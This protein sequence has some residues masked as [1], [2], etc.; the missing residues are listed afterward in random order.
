MRGI[1]N[2][3]QDWLFVG[4]RVDI[5]ESDNLF[6]PVTLPH[7]NKT[8]PTRYVNNADY[9]FVSTYRKYFTLPN[10]LD[11][12]C[13][14]LKFDGAM[15]ETTVY[16][17]GCLLGNHQGGYTPFQFEITDYIRDDDNRLTVY[18]DATEHPHIP[19]YGNLV[20]FLTFGGIY[21]DVHLIVVDACHMRDVIT[22]P[23]D[24]LTHPKVE[25]SVELAHYQAGL[26]LEATL[27][28]STDTI[29]ASRTHRVESEANTFTIANLDNVDLWS[30]DSPTLYTLQ[31]QLTHH[32][33]V[34]DRLEQKIGFRDAKFCDDGHFYL[35]G[36]ALKLF[37]LNRHQTYP[38]IGAAAPK[39]LQE[40][41]ADILKYELGCNIVRTSHY[42]QSPHFLN[43]CD[44]IGLLVFEEV[45]GWQF[46]GDEQWQ[47]L[48]LDDLEAMIKRDRHHPAIVLWGVRV[49]ES[50]DHETFYQRTNA[51][52][53]KLDSS[54]QTGG[55][56]NF[57]ES[58]QLEDVFTLNDF[59]DIIQS[60]RPPHL[61]TEF[62][63]H[64]FPTKTSDHEARRV[65]HALK[66]ASKHNLQFGNDGVAGAIGWCA[67]DY[68]THKEFGS[69]DRICYHGVMD[70]FRLPKF[71][72]YFYRSQKSPDDEIVLFG[73]TN[74]TMG[75]R[76]GGGN[77]PLV[78]F[79]NCEQIELL[80]GDGSQGV[81][82]PNYD[83][84]PHLPYPP[85]VV[86]WAEPYNPWGTSFEDLTV[87]G[88]IDGQCVK[89][90]KIDASHIPHTLVVTADTTQL[91]ADGSD[92]TRVSVKIVDKHG[93]V[94]PYQ[95]SVLTWQIEGNAT[96]VGENPMAL[97]G[98]QG[99]CFV[100]SG[101]TCEKITVTASV[102]T[103]EPTTVSID[104]VDYNN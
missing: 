39:R 66:H 71:A 20:D 69:G 94:L 57:I 37:G 93:N 9:Q 95:S 54:R 26:E 48:V 81:F 38:F 50:P 78:V 15:L 60:P 12:K 58:Q 5:A 33:R 18:V 62:G 89:E 11:G 25:I 51:L 46:I 76:D 19:P 96:F 45:A 103:L 44:E 22:T 101:H 91:F 49:N 83:T 70:V 79:T 2:F 3:N 85:V 6:E 99:A 53:H 59:T 82:E 97:I 13:V 73:A 40:M 100:R 42:A 87:R 77:N 84:Y 32:N 52:A 1:H 92:M 34:I 74:W 90:H 65:A 72:A 29:I 86:K 67:F 55:V 56:R 63:G 102:E 30:L 43:R 8:F 7:S 88:F 41:D 36:E 10:N 35:N 64:M 23:F 61:I 75:D 104:I 16:L 24:V 21:R 4:D 14:F 80:I 31:L 98:G 27:I 17:N 68:H 47:Q 28:D